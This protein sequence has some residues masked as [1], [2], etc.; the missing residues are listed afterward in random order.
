MAGNWH[1]DEDRGRSNQSRGG[2]EPGFFERAGDEV[3]SWFGSGEQGSS[4]DRSEPWGG[5]DWAQTNDRGFGG[6]SGRYRESYYGSEHGFGGFQGDDSG[7]EAQG[8]FGGRGDYQGG[9]QS[10]TSGGQGSQ[11]AGRGRSGSPWDD[12][13][14]SWRQRQ[15]EQMDRDYAEYCSEC[16]QSFHTDFD[17]WRKNRQSQGGSG[18][19][20]SA[21]TGSSAPMAGSGTEEGGRGSGGTASLRTSASIGSDEE[22][23]GTEVG[24]ET[25]ESGRSD[26]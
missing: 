5:G 24:A 2:D 23:G 1:G 9:R 11:T 25:A 17:S 19:G 18:L 13:Y 10:F 6:S 16:Q 12:H 7:G 3:R 20:T 8:G 14:R 15:I 4:Q 26:G 22:S 21:S